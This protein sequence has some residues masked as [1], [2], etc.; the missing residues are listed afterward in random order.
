MTGNETEKR[1]IQVPGAIGRDKLPEAPRKCDLNAPDQT[2]RSRDRLT[3]APSE[4]VPARARTE[5]PVGQC[6]RVQRIVCAVR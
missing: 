6:G 3:P 5:D 1:H 2:I 4:R